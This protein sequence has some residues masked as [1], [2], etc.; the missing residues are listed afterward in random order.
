VSTANSPDSERRSPHRRSGP[1]SRSWG[2]IPHR[3]GVRSRGRRSYR[4]R[5]PG[6]SPAIS[7]ML[8]T[9]YLGRYYV[10]FFIELD[11]RRVH[12][13]GITRHPTGDWTT[14]A[15]RNF[16]V[17]H[18][19]RIRFLIRDHGSPFVAAFDSVFRAEGATIIRTDLRPRRER[20]RGA[21]GRHRAPRTYRSHARLEPCASRTTP[22]R[23]RRALQHP[24]APPIARSTRTRRTRR[25]RIPAWPAD[26][27]TLNLVGAEYSS[28]HADLRL[29]RRRRHRVTA[30]QNCAIHSN[31]PFG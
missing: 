2:W 23:V 21:L 1:S 17:R 31:R 8:R 6:S 29:C 22:R 18:T 12:L 27:T 5:P 20:M 4:R 13:A 19:R 24:P 26:P 28:G 3:N 14:Q 10:L 9:S 16:N 30:L 11:T 15:A 7:S 25:R